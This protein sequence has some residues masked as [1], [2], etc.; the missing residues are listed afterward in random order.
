MVL[1]TNNLFHNIFKNKI[2]PLETTD[3]ISKFRGMQ[4]HITVLIGPKIA[5]QNFVGSRCRTYIKHCYLYNYMDSFSKM[6]SLQRYV[7]RLTVSEFFFF[8]LSRDVC[9]AIDT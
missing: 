8:F 5:Q 3:Y 7:V 9:E 2:I 6:I 4:C 1:V